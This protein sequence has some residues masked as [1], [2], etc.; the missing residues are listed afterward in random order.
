MGKFI[1]RR[2]K[3]DKDLTCK[4]A[5][6]LKQAVQ[7]VIDQ[8]HQNW[9]DEIFKA[10]TTSRTW[11]DDY[12]TKWEIVEITEKKGARKMDGV[13]GVVSHEGEWDCTVYFNYKSEAI[14]FRRHVVEN[15][16]EDG[17]DVSLKDFDIVHEDVAPAD[18]SVY[19]TCEQAVDDGADEL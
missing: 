6:S 3:Y 1:L 10:M 12:G 19:D 14:K 15:L 13:F 4:R 5:S 7:M 11:R 18:V 17:E 9:M 16:K 2:T 8:Y